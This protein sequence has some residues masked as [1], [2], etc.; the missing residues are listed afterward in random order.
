MLGGLRIGFRPTDSYLAYIG[1]TMEKFRYEAPTEY[2]IEA[3]L[4]WKWDW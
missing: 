1:G 2:A 4:R 3:G